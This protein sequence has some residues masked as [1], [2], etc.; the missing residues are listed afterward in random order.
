VGVVAGV[1][2][3]LTDTLRLT[4]HLPLAADRS[5]TFLGKE[6]GREG[7]EGAVA[8]E[9]QEEEAAMAMVAVEEEVEEEE[10]E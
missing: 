6:M 2:Y 1:S 4:L 8:E 5:E 10:E 3:R 7:E 9:E